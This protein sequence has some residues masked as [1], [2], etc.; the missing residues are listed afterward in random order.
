[1]NTRSRGI[2]PKA[3][4]TASRQFDRWHRQHHKGSRL[5][6]GLWQEAV[7]LAREHGVYQTARVLGVNYR[8]LKQRVA[9]AAIQRPVRVKSKPD[10][11][12]L[13]P[14]MMPSGLMEC[15]VEW[16]D[17]SGATVRMH[18]KG[19]GAADLASLASVLRGNGA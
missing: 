14:G 1:M 4:S 16:A 13:L 19:A 11:I 10:F 9:A 15:I 5:P 8:S 2:V 12:E 17:S 6:E 18:L 3:L 7:T